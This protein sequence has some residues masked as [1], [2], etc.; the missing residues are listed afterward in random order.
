MN[1]YINFF[2]EEVVFA[3]VKNIPLLFREELQLT[4]PPT[5]SDLLESSIK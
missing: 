1:I 3:A 2:L 4:A 5:V